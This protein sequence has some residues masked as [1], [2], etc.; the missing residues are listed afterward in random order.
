[1][2]YTL[3]A[4]T[5][6]GLPIRNVIFSFY[7]EGSLLDSFNGGGSGT[8]MLDSANHY[9]LF[10]SNVYLVISADGF[11]TSTI[12]ASVLASDVEFTLD[13]KPG[14]QLL[15]AAASVGGLLYL[16]N[17]KKSK[18]ISGFDL[19]QVPPV[20]KTAIVLSGLGLLAWLLLKSK[21]GNTAVA[22]KAKAEYDAGYA[23]GDYPSITNLEAETYA[24]TLKTAFD[25]CGTD[26][27]AV[28]SVFSNMSKRQDVLLLIFTYG[29]RGYKGCFDGDYFSNH[30][31]NLPQALTSEL[32][33]SELADI[34]SLLSQRGVNYKF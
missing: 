20:A 21:N 33:A 4:V 11:E 22:D 15:I 5:K 16:M 28:T 17:K 9:G 12:D 27:D 19:N 26:N 34:N 31:Y 3:H 10:D 1:M 24:S 25:D 13:E 2:V 6:D 32:S 7:R 18:K 23:A 30:E 8:V 14:S 29:T